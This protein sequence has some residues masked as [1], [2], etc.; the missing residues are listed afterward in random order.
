MAPLFSICIPVFNGIR[1]LR[2]SLDRVII[3]RFP[4]FEVIRPVRTFEPFAYS[5]IV[6][7]YRLQFI[8]SLN[9]KL[10]QIAHA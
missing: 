3:Q 10:K 5:G 8:L 9:K 2:K 1:F 4:E 7:P 6:Q